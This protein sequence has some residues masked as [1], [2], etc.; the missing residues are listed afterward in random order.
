V[1]AFG[2]DYFCWCFSLV[3]AAVLG[4]RWLGGFVPRYFWDVVF[5]SGR[6]SVEDGFALC[7]AFWFLVCD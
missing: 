1:R 5:L 4:W 3:T 6:W 7:R 2:F